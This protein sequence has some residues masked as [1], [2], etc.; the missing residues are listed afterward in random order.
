[1]LKP[2]KPKTLKTKKK[3]FFIVPLTAEFVHI[4]TDYFL[5][6]LAGRKID[7]PS[8]CLRDQ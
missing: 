4:K 6:N 3:K 5:L 1:V 7:A 8:G 2:K